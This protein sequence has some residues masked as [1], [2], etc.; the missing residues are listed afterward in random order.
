MSKKQCDKCDGLGYVCVRCGESE[1]RCTCAYGLQSGGKKPGVAAC[2]CQR[3]KFVPLPAIE[4]TKPD[5]R[6]TP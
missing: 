5:Q 6:R 2:E 3:K 4:I 1:A